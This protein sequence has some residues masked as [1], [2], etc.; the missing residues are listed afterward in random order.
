MSNNRVHSQMQTRILQKSV[1]PVLA[2][3]YQPSKTA[4]QSGKAKSQNWVLEFDVD[5]KRKR[6]PLMGWVGADS[7]DQQVRLTFESR[8]EAIAY[9]KRENIAFTVV[10]SRKPKRIIKTYADNFSADRKNPWTH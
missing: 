4:M 5:V 9:A 6:D 3:I 2:K 1:K 7:T 10:E 8:D